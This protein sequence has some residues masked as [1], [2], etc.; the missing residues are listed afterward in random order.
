MMGNQE[1]DG[2]SR[3]HLGLRFDVHLISTFM[4][5]Y[6]WRRWSVRGWCVLALWTSS[7]W[8]S[9][10]HQGCDLFLRFCQGFQS[11]FY[12]FHLMGRSPEVI[13]SPASSSLCFSHHFPDNLAVNTKIKLFF[14]PKL[15]ALSI[16]LYSKDIC[17]NSFNSTKTGHLNQYLKPNGSVTALY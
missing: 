14:V 2:T 3:T 15:S 8:S 4:L 9:W 12:S 5:S 17:F 10:K 16:V 7:T 11:D 1:I 13:S 6:G